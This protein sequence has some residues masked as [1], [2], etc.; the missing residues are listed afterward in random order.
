LDGEDRVLDPG[1][2]V[3]ADP[4]GPVGLAGVMGGYSSEVNEGTTRIF[5]EA[6]NFN[7]INIRSTST[8]LRLRSEASA[9]F[10]KG[11]SPEVAMQA[12][13][14]AVQLMVD[15][16]HG[17][18]A[19]GFVD[20]YP[21]RSPVEVVDVPSDRIRAVLGLDV[22]PSEV[23]RSLESLG[24]VVEAGPPGPYR[25]F[26]PH[27]RTD[28][29][30]PDDVIEEI[31][32]ILGYETV[33]LTA[34]NGRVPEPV[35]EPAY[36]LRRNLQDRLV[37]AGMQEVITYSL[38]SEAMAGGVGDR[39]LSI[40]NPASQ[41]HVYLR[42]SLRASLLHTLAPNL[43]RRRLAIGLFETARIYLPRSGDLPSEPER[44][45]GVLAGRRPDRWGMPSGDPVDFF[46]MKGILEGAL[47]RLMVAVV[48]EPAEDAQMVP[49]RSAQLVSGGTMIGIIGQVHPEVA[50]R[51]DIDDDVYLFDLHMDA[52]QS[53]L[54]SKPGYR[55]YSRFP[56]TQQDIAV[57]V[58]KGI[59]AGQI[60]AIIRQGRFVVD[61]RPF[62]VYEGPPVPAGQKSVAF[63][64]Q[65][66]APD[67]TLAEEEVNRS[68]GR[69]LQ[70]LQQQ[71]GAQ[72]REA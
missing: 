68:R 50:A 57:I 16:C 53:V 31:V 44:A 61:V 70:Q 14:R 41:D 33:P 64:V 69:T 22:K 39:P 7:G 45:T 52:L 10:E 26:V 32:R 63:A 54:G 12:A 21:G 8:R 48:F 62:D 43:R 72:I 34:I 23:K 9:R 5:L 2:L 29:H 58:E 27:W 35:P 40:V 47:D 37:E 17:R 15:F 66:Q 38:V 49:G 42:E 13:Q 1:M 6:A 60:E 46:D 28:V 25:V 51:F 11:I 71:L 36:T 56:A 30:I 19:D 18:A 67:R 24:F 3:I 55:P 20:V 65:Y 59:R 4:A